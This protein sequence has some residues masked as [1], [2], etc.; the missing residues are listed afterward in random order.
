MGMQFLKRIGPL[1]T[2]IAL[3]RFM[4]ADLAD[5]TIDEIKL[6]ISDINNWWMQRQG[7]PQAPEDFHTTDELIGEAEKELLSE[8]KISEKIPSEEKSNVQSYI[9][10][11]VEN[12]RTRDELRELD[13]A[14]LKEILDATLPGESNYYVIWLEGEIFR[15]NKGRYVHFSWNTK[16]DRVSYKIRDFQNRLMFYSGD[17]PGALTGWTVVSLDLTAVSIWMRARRQYPIVKRTGLGAV[18]SVKD[19]ADRWTIVL[20]IMTKLMPPI[21]PGS[22]PRSIA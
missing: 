14:E 1:L 17:E 22:G 3:E 2:K 21:E 7:N 11:F 9:D 16:G 5:Q 13:A 20:D 10:S 18:G 8:G 15:F 12:V 19:H 6:A 4:S